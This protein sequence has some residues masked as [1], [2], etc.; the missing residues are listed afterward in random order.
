MLC[1]G[2]WLGFEISIGGNVV[3]E[4]PPEIENFLTNID[5]TSFD[6]ESIV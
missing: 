5:V 2:F 4:L 3:Y 1:I 6:V